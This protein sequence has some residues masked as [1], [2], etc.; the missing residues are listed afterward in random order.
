MAVPKPSSWRM[1]SG[2]ELGNLPSRYAPKEKA[3]NHK[4]RC[5]TW[6]WEHAGNR[7]GRPRGPPTPRMQ[8]PIQAALRLTP[9]R[10]VPPQGLP[11][12]GCTCLPPA[13][14]P[15]PWPTTGSCRRVRFLLIC[16]PFGTQHAPRRPRQLGKHCPGRRRP[17]RRG[18][19]YTVYQRLQ[20]P[21]SACTQRSLGTLPFRPRG[22]GRSS[23]LCP[24]TCPTHWEPSPT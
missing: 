6:S 20:H 1:D 22:L 16:L 13:R 2:W 7:L 14:A 19:D 5:T 10:L 11:E 15:T 24:P 8:T 4:P 12:L 21:S 23:A 17:A 3:Q 18:Q 9:N